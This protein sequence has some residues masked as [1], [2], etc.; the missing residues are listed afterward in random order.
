MQKPISPEEFDAEKAAHWGPPRRGQVRPTEASFAAAMCEYERW[1]ESPEGKKAAF[2]AALKKVGNYWIGD[3]TERIYFESSPDKYG[4]RKLGYYDLRGHKFVS[5]MSGTSDAE[6]ESVVAAR[7]K[8]FGTAAAEPSAAPTPLETATA[9]APAR[10]TL[11]PTFDAPHQH[12]VDFISWALGEAKSGYVRASDKDRY[13]EI[14]KEY[15]E[16]FAQRG[17][18]ESLRRGDDLRRFKAY[19]RV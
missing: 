13:T 8:D 2:V 1:L 19:G 15:S 18:P 3:N 9:P 10:A 5:T 11:A 17:Y 14:R 6:F 12:E 7:V 4:P 16:W